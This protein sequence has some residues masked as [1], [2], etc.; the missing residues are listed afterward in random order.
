MR[1]RCNTEA[2]VTTCRENVDALAVWHVSPQGAPTGA[3]TY[4]TAQAFTSTETARRAVTLL[5]RRAITG[6]EREGL[7][8]ALTKLTATV[9]LPPTPW[10]A[11]QV[12][13]PA[14]A[15]GELL[16]RRDAIEAA[17][18]DA[19]TPSRSIAPLEWARD[20]TGIAPPK[21]VTALRA[22]AG[23]NASAGHSPVGRNAIAVARV[24][25][26]LV[27]LW[28]ETEQVKNRRS[29]ARDAVGNPEPLPSSWLAAVQ[30]ASATVLP[31]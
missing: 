21:D 11:T 27:Q 16:T 15:F 5:G 20:L 2:A 26:W 13:Q 22:V 30:T 18:T 31:L 6:P 10:W 24:L 7:E 12:F 9:S 25:R 29:Y 3:W 28:S 8:H 19:R 23:I 4:P 1:G 17:V 14:Q